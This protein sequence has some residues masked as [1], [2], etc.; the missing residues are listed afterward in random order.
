MAASCSSPSDDGMGA[1]DPH[2]QQGPSVGARGRRCVGLGAAVRGIGPPGR[3]CEEG[4]YIGVEIRVLPSLLL[5]ILGL[6]FRCLHLF[7]EW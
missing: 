2:P 7:S 3:G 5:Y 6:Y 4:V 1:E